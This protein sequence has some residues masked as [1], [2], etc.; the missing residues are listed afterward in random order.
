MQPGTTP[1]TR[2]RPLQL[3]LGWL[4]LF[5]LI[6]A[7]APH[8]RLDWLLENLLVISYALL[9]AL[10]YRRFAFS[11]LSY[12]LF[13]LFITLHLIGAHY[14]YSETP[15][16]FWLMEWFGWER[17]HYDRIVHFS[18]GLLLAWPFHELLRRLAQLNTV[19]AAFLAVNMILAFSAFFEIIEAIIAVLV[20]P[21]LG[22]A[23]LGTQGDI[24]DAQKDMGLALLGASLSMSATL[25]LEKRKTTA[26]P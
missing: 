18:Y 17:N 5:W 19:W 6:T 20:S 9:L 3:M 8:N 23:Y 12:G 13:T 25:F 21:E 10:S 24:W 4:L 11:N 1:F 16:G 7:I 26:D 22:I 15:L 14:T 2:N